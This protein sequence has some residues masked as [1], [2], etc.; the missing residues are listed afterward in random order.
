MDPN[1]SKTEV[2]T[3]MAK[4]VEHML[5]EFVGV[6]TGK[7]SP[8]LVE[9]LEV[10]VEAYAS[11]MRLKELAVITTPEARTIMVQP[12]DPSVTGDIE[13]AI[14]ENGKL[15]LNP[16]SDGKVIRLPIPEL[17]EERRV[18]FVKVIRNMAEESR[19]RVRASRKEGMDAA[20]S[21]KADNV[22]TEDQARDF[23]SEVQDLTDRYIK[24]IDAKLADKEQELMTV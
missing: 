7:A 16:V 11:N 2:D 3:S 19:I 23:E 18:E 17:T 4:A 1:S 24:E 13:R 12:F 21:M 20:K 5:Q 8:S 15:G 6:R 9:N 10:H 14:R 22:L